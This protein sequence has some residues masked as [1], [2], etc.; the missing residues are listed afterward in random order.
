MK[1]LIA[2]LL[3][4]ILAL[5]A[6][7]ALAEGDA[8]TTEEETAA[9]EEKAAAEENALLVTV[10]GKEIREN[11]P[12][13]KFWMD[14]IISY[15]GLDEA[16]A[17]Q[18]RQILQLMTMDYALDYAVAETMLEKKG[19]GVT[20]EAVQA[21]LQK[22]WDDTVQSGLAS[23]GITD[24]STEEEIAAARKSVEEQI[25][26]NTGY[27]AESLLNDAAMAYSCRI[28]Q[29]VSALD[30]YIPEEAL[31]VTEEDIDAYYQTVAEQDRET[32]EQYAAMYGMSVPDF[33]QYYSFVAGRQS[34]YKPEGFR[35]INHI[36][37][38]VDEEL[39]NAYN[40]LVSRLAAQGTESAEEPAEE[41]AETA[42]T[43]EPTAEP[44]TQEMVDAAKQAILDS[45][46]DKIAE[47]SEKLANGAAFEDLIQE[48]GTDPGMTDETTRTNG[49]EVHQDSSSWE[50]N[51]KKAAMALE[52]AG[53]V[54]DPVISAYGVHILKYVRD[55]AGGAIEMPEDARQ[56]MTDG[57]VQQKKNA[58]LARLLSEWTAESEIV[59][60]EAGESWKPAEETTETE[61]TTEAQ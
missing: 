46:Q 27:T 28:S 6:T 29:I 35:G 3:A 4:L 47:I 25:E 16:G 42:E 32:L 51:F 14:D 9:T 38:E 36:L 23:A 21:E 43:A 55:I 61:E 52:K 56:T 48:Y 57:A 12:E 10:N 15:Y 31:A 30:K 11:D 24:E 22:L 54:S 58:A 59:W 40:D 18:Y 13:I 2:L 17:A 37:L 45:V 49:Y 1:K 53:D 41:T 8:A 26:A 39:L 20:E 5:S 33:L 50:S 60:T 44:V 34:Y 7:A 19:E